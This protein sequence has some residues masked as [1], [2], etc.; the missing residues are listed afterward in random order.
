MRN[1]V[2]T[3]GRLKDR[4]TPACQ[5]YSHKGGF[6][7][8][9]WILMIVAPALAWAQEYFETSGQTVAF[10]LAPG[11]KAAWNQVATPTKPVA[12]T[13]ASPYPL[14]IRYVSGELRLGAAPAHPAF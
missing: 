1:R 3:S 14:Q 4:L 2:W 13:V 10:T 11:A 12:R 8:R 7:N 9:W 5:T 6:M